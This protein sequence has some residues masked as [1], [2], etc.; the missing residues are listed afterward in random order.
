MDEPIGVQIVMDAAGPGSQAEFWAFALGYRLQDP[1]PGYETWQDLLAASGVPEE[2]WDDASA[3]VPA[4]GNAGPRVFFQKVPEP[5]ERK[6]RVHLDVQVGRGIDDEEQRWTVVLGHVE[7]LK[8][9]GASVVDE[10]T[11]QW[12]ERWMVMT[13]PEG[14]EFCVS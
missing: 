12:G 11:G 7:A 8:L 6:N 9:Q 5:K 3:I 13:D 10:R 1:P 4:E 14:N 2:R